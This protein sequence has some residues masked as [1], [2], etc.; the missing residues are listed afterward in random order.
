VVKAGFNILSH[1]GVI[2]TDRRTDRLSLLIA[3]AALWSKII[4]WR[5]PPYNGGRDENAG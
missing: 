3:N 4:R 5:Y 1:L 2:A